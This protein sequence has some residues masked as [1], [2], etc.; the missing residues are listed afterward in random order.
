[1]VYA[2]VI[3]IFLN[4]AMT[5][6][7]AHLAAKNVK[8]SNWKMAPATLLEIPTSETWTMETVDSVILIFDLAG[9]IWKS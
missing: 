7:I 1:M 6:E 4:E 9:A 8:L 5:W 3:E 2:I